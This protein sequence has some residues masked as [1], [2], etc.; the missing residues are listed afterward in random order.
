V[1]QCVPCFRVSE[2]GQLN[3]EAAT[4]PGLHPL[5]LALS[6]PPA[7]LAHACVDSPLGWRGP[8]GASC[9]AVFAAGGCRRNVTGAGG[10]L[11]SEVCCECG[12][13]IY[14]Q[15][16]YPDGMQ[17]LDGVYMSEQ[18]VSNSSHDSCVNSSDPGKSHSDVRV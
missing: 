17:G 16:G 7:P 6:R 9:D 8:D 1:G 10:R 4:P 14:P 13:G 18:G 3:I 2:T 12:G 15:G 11:A 5:S